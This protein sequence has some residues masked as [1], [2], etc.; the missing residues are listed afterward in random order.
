MVLDKPEDLHKHVVAEGIC[1]LEKVEYGAES[2]RGERNTVIRRGRDG[3]LQVGADGRKMLLRV[4]RLKYEVDE[5]VVG[6]GEL[7]LGYGVQEVRGFGNDLESLFILVLLQERLHLVSNL[8][9]VGHLLGKLS[10]AAID[11]DELWSRHRR[12]FLVLQFVGFS[13]S[14]LQFSPPDVRFGAV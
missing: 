4:F 13:R 9:V 3:L 11:K 10:E 5:Q 14:F 12:F 1:L 8:E 2:G 7:F 6:R